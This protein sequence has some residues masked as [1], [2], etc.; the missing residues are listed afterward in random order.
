MDQY[1]LILD[2][3]LKK[4]NKLFLTKQDLAKLF[5]VSLSTIDNYIKSDD[6]THFPAHCKLGAKGSKG[7]IRFFIY[8]VALFLSR[9]SKGVVHVSTKTTE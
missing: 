2:Q 7:T 5:D 1:N 3:L 6:E 8:D 9:N 4:Y